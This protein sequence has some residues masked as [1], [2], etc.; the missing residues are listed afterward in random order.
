MTAFEDRILARVDAAMARTGRTITLRRITR[1]SGP[2]PL[3]NPPTTTAL[4]A[5]GA[6]S[7][8]AGTMTLTG[9][10]LA[11]RI[12]AG[13]ALVISGHPA[14]YV[15]S[16]DATIA[17]GTVT[18]LFAPNLSAGVSDAAP[19]TLQP[20]ADSAIPARITGFPSRMVD[21]DLIQSGDLMV[22]ISGSQLATRPTPTD[23]L[24]VDGAIHSIVAVDPA[25]IQVQAGLW[26]IHARP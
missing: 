7:S 3:V 9:D 15:V 22:K 6:A 2:D 11:G 20:Q 8:G 10:N 14:A 12:V 17:A 16:A 18:V 25:Y 5:A 21:G 1:T 19:V 13:D 26:S 24:I 23:V 4:R